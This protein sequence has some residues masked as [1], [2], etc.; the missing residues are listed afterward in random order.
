MYFGPANVVRLQESQKEWG[1]LLKTTPREPQLLLAY[2]RS[3][4]ARDGEFLYFEYLLSQ[5][6]TF[7]RSLSVPQWSRD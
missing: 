7:S 2:I 1:A 4:K 3:A 5:K 6:D